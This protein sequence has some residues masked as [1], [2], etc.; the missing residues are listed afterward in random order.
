[1]TASRI[2]RM[3]ALFNAALAR[4]AAERSAFLAA[5][6]A[7]AELR[8][9][10]ERLLAHH[11]EG[12]ATLHD[13]MAGAIDEAMRAPPRDRIGAY[14]L[15]RE[16][17]VGG[18]GKVFLAERRIG[19][20]RQ[21][22]ALKLIRDFPTPSARERL[23]RESS[24]LAELNHPNIARLLD[25]GE[26]DGGEPFLAMEYVEGRPLHDYCEARG[27][28]VHDR[29]RLLV[30]ICRAVQHA[31]QHLIVHRDIKPGNI[32][33][34]DDGTPMLLDFGIAKLVDASDPDATATH[35]FTPAYAA[36]EQISG[37]AVTTATDIYGLGC[38]LYELLSGQTLH[39]V[40][41]D[42]PI[43]APSAAA[44]DAA[45]ARLL[46]GELDTLVGKAMHAEPSRRYASAQALADDVENYLAGRP[47][48]AAPDSFAYRARK[49]A[50][51][52][53]YGVAAAAFVV[54][55]VALFVWRL[56]AEKRRALAAEAHAQAEADGARRSRDFLVSLFE[57]AAP[58][59][60]LG[61]PI[62]ARELID[63]GSEQLGTELKDEPDTAA[64][65]D[66][67]IAGVYAALGDPKTAITMGERALALAAGDTRERAL[68]R[69][70][71][72][73]T[74]GN[75]YDNSDRIDDARRADDEA[76][77]LRERYAP[78]DRAKIAA[79][80]SQAASSAVRRGDHTLARS[81]FDRALDEIAHAS[82][83]DPTQRADVL[84]GVAELDNAEGRL[85]ESLAH[86]K[87]SLQALDSLPRGSPA[88]LESW[89]MLATAETANNDAA[90]AV[91]TLEHALDVA[92]ASLG[93]ENNKVANL[94]N[95]LAVAL[96]AEDRYRESIRHLEKSIAITAKIRPGARVATAYATINLGSLYESL[97]DYAKSESL[98]R[99]GIAAIEA[100]TPD[101]A[102]LDFFRG[103]LARTLMLKG[104]LAG[105]HALIGQ[106][107]KNIAA[108]EGEK[109]F[110]YAFQEFRLSRIDLVS[111]D[112]DAADHDL[113]SAVAKLDPLLPQKHPLRT[114]IDVLRGMI[115]KA[116]GDLGG[117][118]SA[119]ERAEASSGP[120]PIDLAI[121]RMRL[122]G[123]LLARGDLADARRKLGASVP[124]LERSLLPE[125]VE[126][127]EARSYQDDLARRE[128]AR[129]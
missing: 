78:D 50:A 112:A 121:V 82:N 127:V 77:A 99:Q 64:R 43:P 20:T 8:A 26:T 103:N 75:E 11:V 101:D 80:L 4:P 76:L 31:H 126:R 48:V 123:V 14:R 57:A 16:I 36:P 94:E 40:S 27:L 96:N 17:G 47:L 39:D 32:L 67:T 106:A 70:D 29:L 69:A 120:D 44:G 86:A 62:T 15:L 49:F 79:A 52:H 68:L 66:L 89:R 33:V 7:D 25:A 34:R 59:N 61:R 35:V 111:G 19:D 1:M 95:D 84:R 55:L 87:E 23:A 124:V 45:R 2:D 85:A 92:H 107:L 91:A 54:A 109:S 90:A 73:L 104:D 30:P 129:R 110:A 53:R 74:L 13:A 98:M 65:L 63:K 24:L 97:G 116:R 128:P 83:A 10:V 22:V 21:K 9:T 60:T 5:E 71:I 3:E 58:E 18:M 115:A 6:E 12:D 117:A 72:L 42:R 125:A 114:Q 81:F 102:Q 41:R 88:R 51:R 122:A 56:D 119:L 105:A 108:R 100:E 93:E 38:V 46:H 28:D 118:E 113:A 37:R